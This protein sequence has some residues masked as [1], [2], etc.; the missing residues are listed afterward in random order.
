MPFYADNRPAV[1]AIAVETLT[2][3]WLDSGARNCPL[4]ILIPETVEAAD[5][6]DTILWIHGKGGASSDYSDLTERWASYGGYA[7]VQPDMRDSPLVG[8]DPD[9]GDW[10]VRYAET[11]ELASKVP[12]LLGTLGL[13]VGNF[14]VAGHS[15]GSRCADIANGQLVR[16]SLDL[17]V[18]SSLGGLCLSPAGEDNTTQVDP[19]SK[20]VRP[21]FYLT[22]DADGPE[23]VWR[24]RCEPFENT[25]APTFL[26]VYVGGDHGHGYP[27]KK[28][29]TNEPQ[30]NH[31]DDMTLAWWDYLFHAD[32]V[33]YSWL[34][35]GKWAVNSPKKFVRYDV[36]NLP[37]TGL[38]P[39][40]VEPPEIPDYQPPQGDV[41][42]KREPAY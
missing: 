10:E 12:S 41:Q 21:M 24:S 11:K 37:P 32:E 4:R 7:T 34:K 22:G 26:R 23:D 31:T 17:L 5:T 36:R 39:N 18:P 13:F 15:W 33:A 40:K 27:F 20:Q 38:P 2:S 14:S 6:V 35:E 19:W 28:G 3:V 25:T 29:R 16:C 8:L 1:A 9:G 42:S 30:Q